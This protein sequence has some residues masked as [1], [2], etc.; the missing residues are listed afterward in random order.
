[1]ENEQIHTKEYDMI[2]RLMKLPTVVPATTSPLPDTESMEKA[3]QFAADAHPQE[4]SIT[5]KETQAH[6]MKERYKA[7]EYFTQ[8]ESNRLNTFVPG[9]I[10]KTRAILERINRP[11]TLWERIKIQWNRFNAWM[12]K[13]IVIRFQMFG[14]DPIIKAHMRNQNRDVQKDLEEYFDTIDKDPKQ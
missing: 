11:K 13:D 3:K 6:I 14:K 2:T 4:R 7:V 5:N 10:D 1:M 9:D 12:N 8:R